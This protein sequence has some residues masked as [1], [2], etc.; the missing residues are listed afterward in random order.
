MKCS[1]SVSSTAIARLMVML[2]IIVQACAMSGLDRRLFDVRIDTG[3]WSRELLFFDDV[4][5]N[6]GCVVLW[7]A[8][9][10]KL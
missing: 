4:S 1:N 8:R 9:L 2:T 10:A 6:S 3:S 7:R 5:R